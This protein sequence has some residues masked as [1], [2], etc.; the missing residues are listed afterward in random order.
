VSRICPLLGAEGAALRASADR[1]RAVV[2]GLAELIAISRGFL[3]QSILG[4]RSLL[5]LIHSL[6][7]P[8]PGTYDFHGRLAS[9]PDPG[10][11]ALRREA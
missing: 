2:A 10:A 7:A 6:R 4:V 5:A 3:E 11:V 9:A 1:L 8:E